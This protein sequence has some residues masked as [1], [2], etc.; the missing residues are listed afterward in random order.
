MKADNENELI[1]E[2]IENERILKE[3]D[4]EDEEKK[5]EEKKE[6]KEEQKEEEEEEEEDEKEHHHIGIIN[7][8]L[9]KKQFFREKKKFNKLKKKIKEIEELQE[10]LK[11]AKKDLEEKQMKT[12]YNL[13]RIQPKL[14]DFYFLGNEDK[15]LISIKKETVKL[16]PVREKREKYELISVLNQ[17]QTELHSQDNN[18]KNINEVYE[19]YLN[20]E[21]MKK[22]EIKE[23]TSTFILNFVIYALAPILSIIFLIGTFQLISILNSMSDLLKESTVAYYK[24]NFAFN[25]TCNISLETDEN[26]NSTKKNVFDFYNYLYDQSVQETIDFNLMMLTGFIGD[27][28]FKS[29]GFRKSAFVLGLINFGSL[30]WLG[31]FDI[32]LKNN[33]EFD[34]SFA[35]LICILLCYLLIYIGVGGSA[36]LSH[37]IIID[38]HYIYKEFKISK[39]MEKERRNKS[40]HLRELEKYT[41]INNEDTENNNEDSNEIKKGNLNQKNQFDSFFIICLTTTLG[42][43]GKYS[44]N[45]IFNF[46]I[47]HDY[48]NKTYYY[49]CIIILYCISIAISIIFYSIIG[50]VFIKKGIKSKEETDKYRL[51]QICGYIIYY[52]NIMKKK[53]EKCESFKLCCES[54]KNC[55]NEAGCSFCNNLVE[56]CFPDDTDIFGCSCCCC[57]CC[58]YDEYDYI[59]K[60]E[61]F[62]YCYQAQRKSY[63][64]NKFFTN[65]TQ[66]KIVPYMVEFF[67]LQLTTIAFEKQYLK[68]KINIMEKTSFIFIFIFSFF[69][70]FYLTLSLA[71]LIK[72]FQYEEY[73]YLSNYYIDEEEKY[74]KLRNKEA[75]SKLSNE[76]LDGAH[77]ILLFNSIFALIFSSFYLSKTF[78]YK[79]FFFKNNINYIFIPIL[80]N[81]FFFLTL[82]YYCI[83]ISQDNKGYNLISNSSLISIYM[84]IWD[85][86]LS[87]I[88]NNIPDNNDHYDYYKILYIIQIVFSSIPCLIVVL[89][90]TITTISI[91]HDQQYANFIRFYFCL[92]SFCICGGGLWIKM[93]DRCEV[94]FCE[95]CNNSDLE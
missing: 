8:S 23:G 19:K 25:R 3:E 63:W 34:Y 37:K 69:L 79:N 87:I 20:N 10:N 54:V 28:A 29:L 68:S 88:K 16:I 33:I 53:P 72:S 26:D 59:K 58:D 56:I 44:V 41:S 76:I 74:K 89:F 55:C 43:F 77:G 38:I 5:E 95:C 42:Y 30:I 84:K 52:Q 15:Q 11:Y 92:F 93:D 66:K 64:C 83:Y 45:R 57:C 65:D 50:C 2:E 1:C 14:D 39:K 86:I 21:D 62:C 60:K 85:I 13:R 47:E 22:R 32:K 49:N 67:F 75:I 73:S 31:T 9:V 7:L 27:S 81:K 46:F 17:L 36:L 71:K 6:E 91:L 35:K 94:T 48:M 12:E 70:F 51:C 90:I 18:S 24:C 40:I 4:Q 78:R 61:L 82:N 80:T